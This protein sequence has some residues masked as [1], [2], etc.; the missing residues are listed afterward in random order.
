MQPDMSTLVERIL[1]VSVLLLLVIG[2]GAIAAKV[3]RKMI[4]GESDGPAGGFTL[5]QLRQLRKE[6]KMSEEEYRIA[7]A[8]IAKLQASEFL[9][10]GGGGTAPQ[11]GD[12]PGKK[13][14]N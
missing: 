1:I 10:R 5:G 9:P 6:G 12:A 4:R 8:Q 14:S 11:K 13:K 3:A 2:L 7:A